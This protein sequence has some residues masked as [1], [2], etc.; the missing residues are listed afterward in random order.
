MARLARDGV[1]APGSVAIHCVHV[2]AA[3]IEALAASGAAVAHCPRSNAVFGCGAAPLRALLDAGIAVGLG[4]DSPSSVI[5]LDQWSEPGP[6]LLGARTRE[7]DAA[8]LAPADVLEARD[9]RRRARSA[10]P[11]GRGRSCRGCARTSPS[12]TSQAPPTGR[13]TI[14]RPRSC[15]G[16]RRSARR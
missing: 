6:G 1:L 13:W 16:A 3:E 12:S 15:S 9:A 7:A 11:T 8:A 4:S 2:G 10:S 14:R 5:D